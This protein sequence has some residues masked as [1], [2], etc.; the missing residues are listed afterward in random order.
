MDKVLRQDQVMG[1]VKA[2]KIQSICKWT[3]TF[4]PRLFALSLW[5]PNA[6]GYHLPRD[7]GRRLE[8]TNTHPFVLS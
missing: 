5:L 6:Q 7:A 3:M 1:D 8:K 4:A 2:L